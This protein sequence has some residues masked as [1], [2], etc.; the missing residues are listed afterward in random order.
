VR[1][2]LPWSESWLEM[3]AGEGDWLHDIVGT[4]LGT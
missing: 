4:C 1:W 2:Y 3:R